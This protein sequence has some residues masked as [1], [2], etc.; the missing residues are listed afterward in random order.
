[1][2]P[3]AK[4]GT[5]FWGCPPPF[6]LFVFWDE[7]FFRQLMSDRDTNGRNAS[8]GCKCLIINCPLGD[9]ST[10][11]KQDTPPAST[12]V[13]YWGDT[14]SIFVRKTFTKIFSKTH[15]SFYTNYVAEVD[16]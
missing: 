4:V 10:G 8:T 5:F 15:W 14:V 6:F 16:T 3:V 7:V 9:C 2:C 11:K 13:L 12:L 1:M